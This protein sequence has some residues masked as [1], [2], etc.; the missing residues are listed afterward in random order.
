MAG[1]TAA[2]LERLRSRLGSVTNAR[3]QPWLTEVTRDA[4]RHWAWGTGDRNALYLDR[5]YA[6]ASGHADVIGPPAML[7]AF[8]RNSVGYRGGLPGVHSAFGGSHW[9]WHRPLTPGMEIS[10]DTRFTAL[11][12]MPS[13]FAGRMLKQSSTTQFIDQD[14][15]PVAEVDSWSLRFE[16]AAARARNPGSQP[17]AKEGTDTG[18]AAAV[19]PEAPAR[20]ALDKE[21]IAAIAARYRQEAGDAAQERNWGSLQP[22]ASIPS[23]IRG[24]YTSTC[25]VAF[26]MAWGGSFIWSHGYWYDFISRHP[27]ASMR[28]EAGVP[29]AAEA[30]HWDGRAA[31]RAG[32]AG[33]YD[34]GPERVA[35][36]ATLL[37]NWAGP[38]GSLCELYCEVRR[39]NVSGNTLTCTGTIRTLEEVPEGGVA[40]VEILATDQDGHVTA[41]GWGKVRFPR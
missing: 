11:D 31:R 5:D 20:P 19:R 26:E 16:R 22:G 21:A 14:R 27:G 40:T 30:V 38:R 2:E 35:W 3:E 23:I 4:I 15:E 9:K 10:A 29:E 13:R 32:V 34:F 39:F 24:P 33:A 28:S 41:S 1:I 7:Y 17:G 12:D 8:S 18:A 6:R 36:M 37:T 25:A